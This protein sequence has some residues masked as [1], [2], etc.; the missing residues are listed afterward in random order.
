MDAGGQLTSLGPGP[1]RHS[2]PEMDPFP[3]WSAESPP[4]KCAPGLRAGG[5]AWAVY[6]V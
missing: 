6:A 2:P 1:D 3:S 5:A 4:R